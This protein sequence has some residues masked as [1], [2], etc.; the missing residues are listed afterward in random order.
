MNFKLKFHIVHKS[1][2]L[3]KTDI[4]KLLTMTDN[5]MRLGVS[6]YWCTSYDFE[7]AEEKQRK[8]EIILKKK[9][10]IF[11]DPES[12]ISHL[13]QLCSQ[14]YKTLYPEYP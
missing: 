8:D 5:Q 3:K 1:K 2:L 13:K 4:K 11:I 6:I 12:N 9:F 14:K 10:L 7:V